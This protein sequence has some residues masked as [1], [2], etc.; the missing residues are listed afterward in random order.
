MSST[1]LFIG[2]LCIA[3]LVAGGAVAFAVWARGTRR[4]APHITT[5]PA[6]VAGAI[7]PLLLVGAVQ[8]LLVHG[9]AKVLRPQPE[10]TSE[11]MY[12]GPPTA[13]E[14]RRKV[15]AA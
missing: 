6:L 5:G 10:R 14:P 4:S 12:Y 13:S 2:Y 8:W 11:V 1:Q 15:N 3:A 7:W 9:L